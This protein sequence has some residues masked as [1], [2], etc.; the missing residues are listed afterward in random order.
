MSDFRAVAT[1]TAG[2][3]E[4][5]AKPLADDVP[6]A[7]VTMVRPVGTGGGTPNTG[8]NIFLYQVTPNSAWANNDVPTR[9]GDGN[10]VRRPRIGLD[11]HFLLTFFGR[12]NTLEPHRLLGS[13][14]RILHAKPVLTRQAIQ[15]AIAASSFLAGS[16]LADDVERVKFTPLPLTLEE[17]SKLWSVFFQTQYRLSIAY[18]GTVVLVESAASV[19][20]PLP[21]LAR[22]LYV[23]TL[24]TPVIDQVVDAAGD[25]EPIELDST[26]RIRGHWLSSPG[27]F[28]RVG[29]TDVPPATTTFADEEVLAPLPAGLAAGIQGLQVVQPI[30][31]GTPPVAHRGVESDVA[32]FVLHPRIPNV[33]NK[34]SVA[35]L[36]TNTDGTRSADVTVKL[37]PVVRAGQHAL[38][39]LNEA[40]ATTPA[41]FTYA[42]DVPAADTPQ[43]LF[44]VRSVKAG[45]YLVR[46]QVDGAETTLETSGGAFSGPTVAFA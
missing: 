13:T 46:V 6:G 19:R 37:E 12:D 30:D 7:E 34:I 16:K 26:V 8:V 11:L 36:T 5:L 41:A 44:P 3:R 25:D 40:T 45:T 17:L 29:G 31:M 4:L 28:V 18:H 22:N 21:V 24:R 14:V 43:V 23:R 39:L 33:A 9:D 38:L 1:A 15:N 27:A 42:A 10:L 35:G 20:T 2:L 32:A